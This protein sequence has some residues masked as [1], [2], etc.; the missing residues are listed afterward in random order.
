MSEQVQLVITGRD[1]LPETALE[2][3]AECVN[4]MAKWC[5]MHQ[6]GKK[7]LMA[8]DIMEEFKQNVGKQLMGEPRGTA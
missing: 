6:R 1:D 4:F 5:Y 3:Y 7:I 2:K 8:E